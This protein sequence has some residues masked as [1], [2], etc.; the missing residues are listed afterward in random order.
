MIAVE[1]AFSSLADLF[2]GE[3]DAAPVYKPGLVAC[4]CESLADPPQTMFAVAEALY[5]ELADVGPRTFEK[6]AVEVGEDALQAIRSGYDLWRAK[7]A[8]RVKAVPDEGG[9]V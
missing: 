4:I 2:R 8:E 1:A 3:E 9:N 6:Y 5:P 7:R